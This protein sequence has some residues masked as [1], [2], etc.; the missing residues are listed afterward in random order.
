MT[1]QYLIAICIPTLKRPNGLDSLMASIS[2]QT[3][4]KVGSVPVIK[5]CIVD[6]DP[7]ASAKVVVD[8]WKTK[9]PWPVKYEVENNPGIPFVRN[10]LVKMSN[11]ADFIAFIDDDEVASPQWLDELLTTQV[12]YNADVVM[13]PVNPIYQVPPPEWVLKGGFHASGRFNDGITESNLITWNVLIRRSLF[14][15]HNIAFEERMALT[16]GSDVLLGKK[17]KQ[18]GVDFYWS[19]NAV[20]KEINPPE[21]SRIKWLLLRRFRSGTSQ[22]LIRRYSNENFFL[23]KNLTA[24]AKAIV[25]GILKIFTVFWNGKYAVVKGIGYMSQGAGIISGLFGFSYHEYKKSHSN[26]I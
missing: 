10:R 19:S 15:K 24:A 8:D 12:I 11:H 25:I 9:F 7:K 23:L 18:V 21:R 5:V 2:R 13:G 17:M 22:V 14:E 4:S 20:V 16:G 1:K 3:F 6:N 26:N